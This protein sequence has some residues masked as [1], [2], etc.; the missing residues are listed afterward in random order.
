MH[1]NVH[2]E[3]LGHL[4]HP[5]NLAMGVGI[6]LLLIL[7]RMGAG[8]V[9]EHPED[10]GHPPYPSIWV[11][12]EVEELVALGNKVSGGPLGIYLVFTVGCPHHVS[13]L[14]HTDAFIFHFGAELLLVPNDTCPQVLYT[15]RCH[16]PQYFP[17]Y[18]TH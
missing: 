14:T 11:I 10:R 4:E 3:L 7:A 9:L 17:I 13:L 1:I 15:G 18:L 2:V 12:P 5:V 6:G 8:W 16:M